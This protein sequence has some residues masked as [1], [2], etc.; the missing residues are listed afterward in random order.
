MAAGMQGR[1]HLS[2][3]RRELR[4]LP[5][6]FLFSANP[7][8]VGLW[9]TFRKVCSS[10]DP[11]ENVPNHPAEA[12]FLM[13]QKLTIKINRTSQTLD[14]KREILT[15]QWTRQPSEHPSPE[16]F[17][18]CPAESPLQNPVLAELS[19]SALTRSPRLS[20]ARC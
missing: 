1:S 19:A 3:G 2:T 9:A 7:S 6:T 4:T 18:S 15:S 20:K 10:F 13:P 17:T 8:P 5:L 14:L 16:E 11:P 12:A